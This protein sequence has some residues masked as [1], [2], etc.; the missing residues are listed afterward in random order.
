MGLL[1]LKINGKEIV[2]EDQSTLTIKRSPI[3]YINYDDLPKEVKV[4]G[5]D[6]LRE[7][8]FTLNLNDVEYDTEI[9]GG[10]ILLYK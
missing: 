9:F 3:G 8:K 10:S 2:C 5:I 4:K 7:N 6:F 1:K